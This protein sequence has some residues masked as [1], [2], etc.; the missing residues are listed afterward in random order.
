MIVNIDRL[1]AALIEA[2]VILSR[3]NLPSRLKTRWENAL[4][5]AHR[6]L[7]ENP[8]I[9]WTNADELLI[10]SPPDARRGETAGKF[11]LASFNSCRREE[12]ANT[13]CPA[14]AEGFPCWHR[15][16]VKL[17]RIYQGEHRREITLRA[18]SENRGASLNRTSQFA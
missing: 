17:L 3:Q 16:A 12:E 18:A 9:C 14:F 10:L 13:P 6:Q 7:I 8:H 1:D 15:A 11:Y 4:E 5:K 2:Q